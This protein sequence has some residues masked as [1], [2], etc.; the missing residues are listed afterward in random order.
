MGEPTLFS[1]LHFCPVDTDD[2]VPF[3]LLQNP[4]EAFNGQGISA[5]SS[6]I[7][8]LNRYNSFEFHIRGTIS[9]FFISYRQHKFFFFF[10]K[11]ILSDLFV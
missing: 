3:Q 9:S 5:T 6:L 2:P 8:L 1:S 10:K 11:S 7:A 4:S